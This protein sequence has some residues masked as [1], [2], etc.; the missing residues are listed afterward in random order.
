MTTLSARKRRVRRR[1]RITG[2]SALTSL[3]VT[4]IGFLTWFHIVFPAD[5]EAT[6]EVYRDDRVVVTPVDGVV[7]MASTT[8]TS[9]TGL[10]FFPG[11]RVDPFAYL[12]P[13]VDIAASGTTVVIVDPLFNMALF[14]QRSMDELTSHSPNITQ[15]VL[16][17]HS[18][19]GVKACM[20][21]DNDQVAALWLLASY[22][23][24]DISGLDINVVE[25]LAAQD[26][27][28]DDDARGLA[29]ANLPEGFTTLTLDGANHASFGTY[30]PQP[31]D[32]V[33]TL[34]RDDMRQ[35]MTDLWNQVVTRPPGLPAQ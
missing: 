7:V 16:A 31:G 34:N 25:V 21:A 13:F 18:L 20:E 33:A 24:T 35:A 4:V 11:A 6:L 12:H 8:Y 23:A 14:D 2:W 28:M 29:Q 5:R 1:I 26:G 10:L 9:T 17:G 30:G 32:G 22:C 3:L 15:W 19:G 27:L